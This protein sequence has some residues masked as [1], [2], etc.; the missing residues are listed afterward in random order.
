MTTLHQLD[1]LVP[2]LTVLMFFVDARAREAPCETGL[3]SLARSSSKSIAEDIRENFNSSHSPTYL[4]VILMAHYVIE[5]NR[6]ECIA[7]GLCYSM[8][9]THFESDVDGKSQ[10]VGGDTDASSSRGVFEDD[11]RDVAE[12]AEMSCPVSVI[13]VADQ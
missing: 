2:I 4:D 5:I 10:I 8:D 7:C 6:D 3:S 12:N 1:R 11:E 9:P 13:T